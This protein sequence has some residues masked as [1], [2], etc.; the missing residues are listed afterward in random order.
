MLSLVLFNVGCDQF[1]KSLV[2]EKVSY[3]ERID[4]IPDTFTLTKVENTGAF[5]SLGN[6]LNPLAKSVLL[7]Y[8]PAL[9]LLVMLAYILRQQEGSTIVILGLCFMAGGGIGNLLDR[10][11]YGSVTD[12]LHLDFGFFQT[13]IFNLA[14]V[15]IMI[16]GISILL[17]SILP[18]RSMPAA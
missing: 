10:I 6:S 7:I 16:G 12:F 3:Y 11:I 15:S 2:R 1:S 17:F 4:I 18:P 8:L 14:D 5:L 13:G 9:A